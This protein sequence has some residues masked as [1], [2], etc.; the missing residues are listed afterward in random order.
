LVK[1]LRDYNSSASA[2]DVRRKED[3]ESKSKR[4]P[5]RVELAGVP[6]N[7]RMRIQAAIERA[8]EEHD[9]PKFKR[10]LLR[11]GIGES[12]AAYERLLR[13]WGEHLGV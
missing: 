11:L 9:L 8:A 3:A 13:F 10:A 4:N 1:R 5:L 2:E 6:Y 12:S 7:E